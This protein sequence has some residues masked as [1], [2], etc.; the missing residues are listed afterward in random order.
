[1]K[2]GFTI[3]Y[4][5]DPESPKSTSFI[6]SGDNIA[7]DYDNQLGLT[8]ANDLKGMDYTTL[9]TTFGG[10]LP[11]YGLAQFLSSNMQALQV[12]TTGHYGCTVR[13]YD[14][15]D[16][17]VILAMEQIDLVDVG[18]LGPVAQQIAPNLCV[19]FFGQGRVSKGNRPYRW[20]Y[21]NA[22]AAALPYNSLMSAPSNAPL[23]TYLYQMRQVLDELVA[24][25]P[26]NAQVNNTWQ[27]VRLSTKIYKGQFRA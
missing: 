5:V 26:S 17:D 25:A 12:E 19:G 15:L 20:G 23:G 13:L 8:E 9:L 14:D 10:A 7:P 16:P 1:M 6:V 27:R 11:A 18:S 24:Y 4:G 3:F 22:Q 21:I 2:M